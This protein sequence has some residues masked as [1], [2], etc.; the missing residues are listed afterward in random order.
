[1]TTHMTISEAKNGSSRI[2]KR[3]GMDLGATKQMKDP[4]QLPQ[5]ATIIWLVLKI[6]FTTG[7]SVVGERRAADAGRSLPRHRPA[8]MVAPV[9]TELSAMVTQVAR[10]ARAHRMGEHEQQSRGR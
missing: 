10:A 4:A 6:R 3:P 7:V 1:M 2:G 5:T 8:G 9:I